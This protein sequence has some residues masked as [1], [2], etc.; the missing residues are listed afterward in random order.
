M[1]N[2]P[3][4]DGV[5]H[6]GFEPL[7]ATPMAESRHPGSLFT[8]PHRNTLEALKLLCPWF[9]ALLLGVLTALTGSFISVNCDFLGDF[10]FGF[11]R[12]LLFS[13]RTRCCGGSDNVN[14]LQG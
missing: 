10:R 14:F 11:C 3:G 12:G 7:D 9:V 8:T 1:S 4:D 13:D 5:V 6:D 2:V